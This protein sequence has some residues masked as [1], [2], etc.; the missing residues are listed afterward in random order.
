MCCITSNQKDA[1]EGKC[2]KDKG[3]DLWYS[4][5]PLAEFRLIPMSCLL[6]RSSKTTASTAMAANFGCI[7]NAVG[8]ND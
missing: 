2:K 7:R 3:H 8:Y 1:V 5:G 6:Y 4:P